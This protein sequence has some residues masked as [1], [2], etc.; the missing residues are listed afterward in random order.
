ML[1]L[2]AVQNLVARWWFNYDQGNF[3]ELGEMITADTHFSCRSDSGDHEFEEFFRADVS[4]R[5]EVLAWQ[6]DHRLRSPYPL[7]H[8]GTNI[9][10]TSA[11]KDEATFLSY[12]HVTQVTDGAIANVASGVCGGRVRDEH[13]IVRIADL[14]TVLDTTSSQTFDTLF[15]AK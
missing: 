8:N 2:N 15:P 3:D 5:D 1:D 11:S 7:R 13:G 4:G 10:I 14:V 12:I 6:I 9:H